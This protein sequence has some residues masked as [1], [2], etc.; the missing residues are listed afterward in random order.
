[1]KP[2]EDPTEGKTLQQ[3]MALLDLWLWEEEL[4]GDGD[5]S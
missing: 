2:A 1:M 4:S 3:L 5:E